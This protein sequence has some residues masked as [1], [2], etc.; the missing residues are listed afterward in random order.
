MSEPN[1]ANRGVIEMRHVAVGVLALGALLAAVF[2]WQHIW[3]ILRDARTL[4]L[5]GWLVGLVGLAL[6]IGRRRQQSAVRM[7]IG[8]LL[9]SL[10]LALMSVPL[11]ARGLLTGIRVGYAG[12][13]LAVLPHAWRIWR[14]ESGRRLK[15]SADPLTRG[16][17]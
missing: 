10:G 11:D 9:A 1:Y 7:A 13:L 14:P 5:I 17:L 3:H 4:A 15:N 12:S 2:G 8:L 16:V 6:L